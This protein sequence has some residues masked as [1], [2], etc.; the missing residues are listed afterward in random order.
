MRDRTYFRGTPE[1]RNEILEKIR[2]VTQIAIEEIGE[3]R[4]FTRAKP[5]LLAIFLS[6]LVLLP[7][8][9]RSFSDYFLT[10][11]LSIKL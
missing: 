3:T 7:E 2:E 10:D 1:T 6:G 11:C 4:L 8:T 9:P 5:E